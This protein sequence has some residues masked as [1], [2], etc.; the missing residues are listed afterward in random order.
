MLRPLSFLLI[1]PQVA[2]LAAP[3]WA[4]T[5]ELSAS[6]IEADLEFARGLAAQWGFVDIA[7]GVLDGL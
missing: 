6:Q 1:A 7:E 5:Q 4:A 2:F 3:G